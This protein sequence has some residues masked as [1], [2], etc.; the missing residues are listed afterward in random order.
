MAA[1]MANAERPPFITHPL[2]GVNETDGDYGYRPTLE[3]NYRG[4]WI[5]AFT[6]IFV[7]CATTL[8][9]VVSQAS[10]YGASIDAGTTASI[11]IIGA[12]ALG[13]GGWL[14]F[15]A[16]NLRRAKR[17]ARELARE[18]AGNGRKLGDLD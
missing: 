14:I 10:F 6:L 17:Y 9:A 13:I 8:A 16:V 4:V 18:R 11:V 15:R 1:V 2:L 3:R 7:V 12:A 5:F